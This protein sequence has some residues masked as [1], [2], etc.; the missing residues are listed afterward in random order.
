MEQSLLIMKSFFIGLYNLWYFRKVIWNFR[1]WDY[2]FN[3]ELLTASLKYTVKG[4]K[5]R[6]RRTKYISEMESVILMLEKVKSDKFIKEAERHVG[7]ECKGF[8]FLEEVHG[9]DYVELKP[10]LGND[11]EKSKEVIVL[12]NKLEADNWN[13]LWD[14][15]KTNM[16]KWWD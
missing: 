11:P 1:H 6:G 4:T 8:T 2:Q 5:K 15:I 3:L 16:Q 13:N 12:A 7:Y 9:K 14:S 10:R